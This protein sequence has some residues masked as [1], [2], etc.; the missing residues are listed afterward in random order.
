MKMKFPRHLGIW[1]L[2]CAGWVPATSI[3]GSQ[4]PCRTPSLGAL[5]RQLR[6]ARA[7]ERQHHVPLYTNDDLRVRSVPPSKSRKGTPPTKI[8]QPLPSVAKPASPPPEESGEKYFR[9]KAEAIRSRLELHRRQLA[10]LE[11]QWGLASIEYYSNPQKT[12]QEESTPTFHADTNKLRAKIEATKRQIA[13]DEK[14]MVALKE[15][16]RR[17]GGDPG[18]IRQ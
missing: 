6:E 2:A 7:K 15:E 8:E 17:K 3:L 11:Q 4:Q 13:E 16:L 14:A 18:W 12:L 5:A 10:V 9:A 1:A